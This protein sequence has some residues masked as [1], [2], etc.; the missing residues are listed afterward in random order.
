MLV[1]AR[2][3]DV[4][5]GGGE[6]GEGG[7]GRGDVSAGESDSIADHAISIAIYITICSYMHFVL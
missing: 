6:R 5:D 3:A 4:L 1:D 7:L 2:D